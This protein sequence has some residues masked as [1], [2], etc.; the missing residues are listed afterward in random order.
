MQR[1]HFTHDARDGGDSRNQPWERWGELGRGGAGVALKV[2]ERDSSDIIRGEAW[3]SEHTA[4]PS[5]PAKWSLVILLYSQGHPRG[6]IAGGCSA[7]GARAGLESRC[8]P[9]QLGLGSGFPDPSQNSGQ[10]PHPSPHLG[11]GPQIPAYLLFPCAFLKALRTAWLKTAGLPAVCP[12]EPGCGS[13]A[14]LGSGPSRPRKEEVTLCRP[15][16]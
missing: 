4:P 10:V 14:V 12:W 16:R 3:C 11:P 13:P 9:S 7:R 6:G 5:N 1:R 2:A 8:P 15:R